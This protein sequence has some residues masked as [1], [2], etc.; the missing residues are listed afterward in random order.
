MR[1]PSRRK[2]LFR[3]YEQAIFHKDYSYQERSYSFYLLLRPLLEFL[4]DRLV[5]SLEEAA[6]ESELYLLCHK[7][8]DS[9]DPSRSSIVPYLENCL[10]FTIGD[11]LKDLDLEELTEEVLLADPGEEYTLDEEFYWKNI[12]F[13][14][15]YVGKC[16]T[17]GEKYIIYTIIE[18]D[19]KDLSV[20]RLAK[21]LNRKRWQMKEKLLE[22]KEVFELEDINVR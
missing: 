20:T 3:N 8:F 18:S 1:I 21:R 10:D 6:A 4:K 14:N 2:K 5:G 13:Q 11:Y 15:T 22:I 17:R 16:F 12:L 19:E 7:V 9:Y